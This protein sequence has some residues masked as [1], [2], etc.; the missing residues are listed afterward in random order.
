MRCS[1]F[2]AFTSTAV[3][4]VAPVCVLGRVPHATCSLPRRTARPFAAVAGVY[5]G[6][7]DEGK[8]VLQPLRELA[9]PIADFSGPMP[10]VDGQKL[11]D[12]DYPDGRFYYWK[13]LS[14]TRWATT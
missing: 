13:S 5:A 3:D 8:R 2:R 12:D 11:L 6:D 7:Q 1:I 9:E 4:D 10:Y 14:S